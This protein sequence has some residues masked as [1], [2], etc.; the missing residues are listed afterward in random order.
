MVIFLAFSFYYLPERML[1]YLV[2]SFITFRLVEVVNIGL[3]DFSFYS[4]SSL[5]GVR[6]GGLAGCV[7]RQVRNNLLFSGDFLIGPSIYTSVGVSCFSLFLSPT[8]IFT[9]PKYST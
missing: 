2:D 8:R 3:K 1:C 4:S 9:P 5:K 6:E 7:G